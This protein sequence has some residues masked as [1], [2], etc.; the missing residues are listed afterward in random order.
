MVEDMNYILVKTLV[1]KAIRD[2][3]TDPQRTVR[4]LVDMALQFADSRFQ[5]QFFSAASKILSDEYS[6]YYALATETLAKVNEEALLTVSMNLGYNSLYC[7]CKYIRSHEAADGYNIPWTVAL[8]VCDG[9][10]QDRLHEIIAQGEELGI[11]TWH[12]FS[13][14]K[15]IYDCLSIAA[16]HSGSAFI[17]FCEADELDMSV[18]DIA[19]ETHNAILLVPY[20]KDADVACSLLREGGILFGLYCTYGDEDADA[21]ESGALVQDMEQLYP[22]VCVF[23]PQMGCSEACRERVY[24]WI[25][26]IRLNQKFRTILWELYEDMLLVD[27]VISDEPCWV[28]FDSEGQL[29]THKGKCHNSDWNIFQHDLQDILRKSFPR[30]K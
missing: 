14:K 19:T 28:G 9:R 20:D 30:S 1:S 5:H 10:S 4:N 29:H 17:C 21:I 15:G 22:A 6:G 7:G 18:L 24:R 11:R 26:D 12:L 2:I 3:K 8:S 13:K 16:E 27:E 25:K 23:K